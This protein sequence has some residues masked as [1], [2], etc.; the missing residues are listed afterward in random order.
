[1]IKRPILINV[2]APASQDM[3]PCLRFSDSTLAAGP[4]APPAPPIS[5]N[6]NQGA[7]PPVPPL[8]RHLHYGGS[9]IA[10]NGGIG[11]KPEKHRTFRQ[12]KRLELIV[13]LENAAM[14]EQATA[15]MLCI[16]V[17]RLR[18]IKKSADYLKT[19]MRLTFGIVVDHEARLSQIKEQRKEILTSMLPQALQV[20]ANV[21]NKPTAT[22]SIAEAKLQVAVAQD[23]LDREGSLA[24]VSRTEVKPVASFDWNPLDASNQSIFDV[25]RGAATANAARYASGGSDPNGVQ[26]TIE[27]S[28]AFSESSTIDIKEQQEALELL[29]K[30]ALAGLIPTGNMVN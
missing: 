24:K 16:S 17:P 19:R 15:A 2:S 28:K 23:M 1:M 27:L 7:I 18:T 22:L 4:P 13:Q 25:I 6:L 20:I 3:R 14:P 29:E 11:C 9:P 26:D 30:Q 5:F 10:T 8:K 12:Q 21:L